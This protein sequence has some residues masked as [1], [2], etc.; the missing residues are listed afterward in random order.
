MGLSVRPGSSLGQVIGYAHGPG[1]FR[2]RTPTH[3]NVYSHVHLKKDHEHFIIGLHDTQIHIFHRI[4]KQLLGKRRPDH[5]KKFYPTRTQKLDFPHVYTISIPVFILLSSVLKGTF[6]YFL[7]SVC[8]G[9]EMM[10]STQFI[11]SCG[12]FFR[13]YFG[14][15]NA[16]SRR[17]GIQGLEFCRQTSLLGHQCWRWR[18][19]CLLPFERADLYSTLIPTFFGSGLDHNNNT[20]PPS[21][22]TSA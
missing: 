3:H 10:G 9:V 20:P 15:R 21:S 17:T 16:S 19:R 18:G 22:P 1:L 8:R 13:F 4:S 5:L 14:V 11:F 6:S 2:D 7:L 12:L